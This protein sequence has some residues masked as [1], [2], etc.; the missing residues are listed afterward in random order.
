MAQKF[1]VEI[2]FDLTPDEH[3]AMAA[4]IQLA[5][6]LTLA[7]FSG[8]TTMGNGGGDCTDDPNGMICD[9]PSDGV[10]R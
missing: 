7:R 8:N 2:G 1:F 9:R 6:R 5:V 3:K 10:K 4:A